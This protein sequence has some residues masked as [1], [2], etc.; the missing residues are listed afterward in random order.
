M[1]W[2]EEQNNKQNDYGEENEE[3]EAAKE[4]PVLP[5]F[6]QYEYSQKWLEENPKIEIPPEV[7][8]DVDNDWIL[9][10]RGRRSYHSSILPAET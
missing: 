5:V 7:K 4:K 2:E 6:N 9:L 8:D 1:K 3:G 10:P